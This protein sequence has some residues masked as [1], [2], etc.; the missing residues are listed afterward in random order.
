MGGAEQV[1]VCLVLMPYAP[2]ERPSLGLSLLKA[3]L[4]A[5]EI[6]SEVVYANLAF[7]RRAGYHNYRFLE[8]GGTESLIAEWTF[9]SSIFPDFAPDEAAYFKLIVD[10]HGVLA[11]E[12]LG[13]DEIAFVW[14]QVRSLASA[15]VDAAARDIL[16]RR[17]RIVGC[18]SMLYQ[19]TASLALLKR[20]RELAPEVV[21]L[22]GGAN[23]EGELGVALVR[24]FPWVDFAVSGEADELF[25][26]LCRL[27]LEKG[28]DVAMQELP[29]GVIGQVHLRDPSIA[30]DLAANPPR[31]IVTDLDALPLPNFDDY[32]RSL[33]EAKFSREIRPG[34]IMEGS[35]G[36]WWGARHPCSFCGLNGLART[37]RKKSNGRILDEFS[38]LSAKYGLHDFIQADTIVDPGY[39]H[40]VLPALAAGDRRYRILIETKAN[41]TKDDLRIMRDA[42][43]QLIQPGIESLHDSVLELM[44]KGTSLMQNVQTMKHARELCIAIS[45]NLL[46]GFPGEQDEWYQE[47]SAWL[48]LIAHLQPPNHMTKIRY[49]R[50]SVYQRDPARY[51]LEL[52]PL[53]TYAQV[54]PFGQESLEHLAYFFEQRDPEIGFNRMRQAGTGRLAVQDQVRRWIGLFTGPEPPRLEAHATDG[55]LEIRDTRPCALEPRRRLDELQS[56][57]LELCDSVLVRDDLP[58]RLAAGGAR[59]W[60]RLE[61]AEA[62][63]GLREG[64]LLL[65]HD[66][67]LLGLP[68]LGATPRLVA[69][70]DIPGG[71][72]SGPDFA[73]IR[74]WL[75]DR[76]L[77]A[78]GDLALAQLCAEPRR[79]GEAA[80][81]TT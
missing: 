32:F 38:A 73:F 34:L 72:A 16:R 45:W 61:I 4:A 55:I 3:C 19:H 75:L 60:S 43:V 78:F 50:F 21:T 54:Y 2:L 48:P 81:S 51:G 33:A 59:A 24:E 17:P 39:I 37:Y 77:I 22:M 67:K 74:R 58:G 6:R 65:E 14:K 36:C 23:C 7:A 57:I 40:D 26:G 20:I 30:R 69:M 35:R 5:A 28:R 27:L 12:S 10:N 29:R 9:A 1:D 76:R 70:E 11:P 64:R 53:R 18:S 66:G 49:D 8:L 79:P 47:M 52:V 56:R 71:F 46:S 25:G 62:V 15:F 41:L 31:A 68:I 80:R 63:T 42:G 44:S 13:A